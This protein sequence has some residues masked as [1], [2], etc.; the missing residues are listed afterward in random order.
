MPSC[1]AVCADRHMGIECR[2]QPLADAPGNGGC[3]P[4]L[5]SHRRVRRRPCWTTPI[6]PA[7]CPSCEGSQ[8]NRHWRNAK[9]PA[10]SDMRCRELPQG[11][12]GFGEGRQRQS[13]EGA[14]P[15]TPRHEDH[16]TCSIV[17]WRHSK[18]RSRP[19]VCLTSTRVATLC[20]SNCL[21]TSFVE[22]R[23]RNPSDSAT[24]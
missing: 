3:S 9:L 2:L 23:N 1:C 21:L 6:A 10:A 24:M 18:K 20:P 19:V 11:H 17:C 15:D 5:H 7:E 16:S 8:R 13:S 22:V 12:D 4:P 14:D